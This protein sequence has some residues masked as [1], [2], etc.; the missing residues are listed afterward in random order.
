MIHTLSPTQ[1]HPHLPAAALPSQALAADYAT[2]S[3]LRRMALHQQRKPLIHS[4]E[5]IGMVLQHHPELAAFI[6]ESDLGSVHLE[7]GA[8]KLATRTAFEHSNFA[9]VRKHLQLV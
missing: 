1:P 4:G 3:S 7:V 2:I 6:D 9:A 8:L 5:F